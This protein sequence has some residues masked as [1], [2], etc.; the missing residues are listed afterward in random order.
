MLLPKRNPALCR[1][2]PSWDLWKLYSPDKE[3]G[4][5]WDLSSLTPSSRS[6]FLPAFLALVFPFFQLVVMKC[7]FLSSQW[8]TPPF[9]PRSLFGFLVVVVARVLFPFLARRRP[10][11][12]R[13]NERM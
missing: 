7:I 2:I 6:I 3:K 4:L 10:V 11:R 13:R 8:P 12:L 9:A 1:R 5:A